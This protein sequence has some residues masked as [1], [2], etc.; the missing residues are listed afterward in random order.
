MAKEVKQRKDLKPF[1]EMSKK[2]LMQEQEA[3]EQTYQ[4]FKARGLSLDMSRGKP[5]AQQLDLSMGILD[6]LDGRSIMKLSHGV[7]VRNYGVLDG[8]PEA[9]E[10][11]AD[12]VDARPE[13]V[14][15][16]GSS[17][18]NVMFDTVVRGMLVGFGGCKPWCKLPKIRFLCPV[19]GYDR[20][21]AITEH[22]GIDM[23]NIP[24]HEDGPDM[25][26]I[27]KLVSADESIKGIWCV[28]KFSNPQG[29]VYSDE[30]C[31]RFAHLKPAAKDFRVFWDNAYSV[32]YLYDAVEIPNILELA[33][34]AGNPDMF[35][36]FVSTSKI[37]FSGGGLAAFVS[38]EA[39]VF[40]MKQT[41]TVQTIGYDKVNML[42]HA[43]FFKDKEAVLEHMRKHAEILRPKF[44]MVLSILDRDLGGRGAGKWGNPKGGYF[45]TFEGLNGCA[46][47]IVELAKGAGVVMTDA[48]APFPYHK[49]PNDSMIRIAP[50]FPTLEA[51][52]QATNIFTVCVRLATIE[53]LLAEM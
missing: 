6:M 48:G 17:S 32:H 7:D 37:T 21:F 28:P 20:H 30:V 10:L 43:K 1:G 11:M 5:S 18:L 19:P 31:E 26:M 52:E 16:L 23:I 9:K 50:S 12:L 13:Q 40:E 39:N 45:I 49:D 2:K 35:F 42:R 38:S 4:S 51:L 41:M 33:N 44:E 53:K 46:K 8:L 36:E 15:V 27:E 24:M 25:D 34:K 14:I 47:R 29:V 3:L 22:F